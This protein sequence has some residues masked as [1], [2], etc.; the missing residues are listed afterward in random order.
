MKSGAG[1]GSLAVVWGFLL[2]F[3]ALCLWPT[4]GESEYSAC[5]G[6]A[7]RDPAVREPPSEGLPGR[8]RGRRLLCVYLGGRE[9]VPMFVCGGLPLYVCVWGGVLFCERACVYVG[10]VRVCERGSLFECV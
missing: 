8:G 5:P 7:A 3:A 4:N 2:V 6:G 1:G 10:V 9:G